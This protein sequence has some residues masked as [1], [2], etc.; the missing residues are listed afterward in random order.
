MSSGGLLQNSH[1]RLES[2]RKAV[3]RGNRC[4]GYSGSRQPDFRTTGLPTGLAQRQ[5]S[6]G[7]LY[8]Q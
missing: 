8:M 7:R 2:P 3:E 5:F 4:L 1:T 6:N